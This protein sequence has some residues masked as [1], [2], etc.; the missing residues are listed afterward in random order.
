LRGSRIGWGLEFEDAAAPEGGR[1]GGFRWL[2][3]RSSWAACASAIWRVIRRARRFQLNKVKDV[4][5]STMPS[6]DFC[7]P[8]SVDHSTLSPESE[9]GS[10][11]PEVSSTAFSA[12]PPGLQPAPLMDMDL[13]AICPLV[14]H[15]MPPTRFLSIG[16]RFCSTLPSDPTSRRHPCASL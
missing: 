2:S 12:Q 5:H 10:R 6:A 9:T 7:R 16:S 15:R 8:V 1:F 14:R 11:S 4:P 3:R 13:A